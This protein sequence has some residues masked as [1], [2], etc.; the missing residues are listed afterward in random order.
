MADTDGLPD[1]YRSWL[2]REVCCRLRFT[3]I[4]NFEAVTRNCRSSNHLLELLCCLVTIS[5]HLLC[6][7]VYWRASINSRPPA[8]ISVN[9]SGCGWDWRQLRISSH[10]ASGEGGRFDE[11]DVM[12]TEDASGRRWISTMSFPVFSRSC[13]KFSTLLSD[14]NL[15]A[16]GRGSYTNDCYAFFS[17]PYPCLT[18][19]MSSMAH[20]ST[21]SF[22]LH[23]WFHFR[24]SDVHDCGEHN[25]LI[26]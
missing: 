25:F 14:V 17:F 13:H 16:G 15:N 10:T 6:S 7:S 3:T 8:A 11:D 20:A 18:N 22:C 9:L 24:S 26:L 12:P 5:M 1:E 4:P 23:G 21:C 19:S 2:A